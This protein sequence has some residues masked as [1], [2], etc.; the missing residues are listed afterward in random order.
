MI[1]NGNSPQLQTT[2][3]AIHEALVTEPECGP[4]RLQSFLS[5]NPCNDPILPLL[6]AI[7]D[8]RSAL[9]SETDRT[10]TIDKWLTQ[11]SG[12]KPGYFAPARIPTRMQS[13]LCLMWQH[14][15]QALRKQL[16]FGRQLGIIPESGGVFA[17]A[18]GTCC[19][20]VIDYTFNGTVPEMQPIAVMENPKSLF[21]LRDGIAQIKSASSQNALK[22]ILTSGHKLVYHRGVLVHVDRR[23]ECGVF[24]PTI[25]T[26]LLAEIL[27]Q[28]LLEVRPEDFRSCLEVGSGSGLLCA[29]LLENNPVLKEL[30]AID[31][32]FT[33][34]A[35]TEKNCRLALAARVKVPA[36][37]YLAGAY[38][39][40]LFRRR[41]DLC[42]SN[43]PYV[44]C[45]TTSR[46]TDRSRFG[47]NR[48]ATAGTDLLQELLRNV[49]HILNPEGAMLLITSSLSR[50]SVEGSLDSRYSFDLPLGP[51]GFEAVFDVDSVVADEEW[52]NFLTEDRGLIER[53]GSYYHTLV[54]MIITKQ[55]D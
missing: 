19:C 38:Q 54:P 43:P 23:H 7:S 40:N 21:D 37:R 35:C 17:F 36:V 10:Q 6:L 45:P 30:L 48:R 25:D 3:A 53:D 4:H 34:I 55:R 44:P 20:I 9:P 26:V 50:Q 42:I 18:A 1:Q 28:Y 24:G 31:S 39:P 14:F 13:V 2:I 47:H 46:A 22:R 5:D 29:T 41:F 8:S 11:V 33:S 15:E 49:D 12:C 51:N 16:R 32:D 27:V 52:L